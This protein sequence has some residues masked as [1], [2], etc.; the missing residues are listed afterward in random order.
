MQLTGTS[1]VNCRISLGENM[2]AMQCKEQ[3]DNVQANSSNGDAFQ[4]SRG[5]NDHLNLTVTPP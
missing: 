1:S 4:N 5:V 2:H 3:F